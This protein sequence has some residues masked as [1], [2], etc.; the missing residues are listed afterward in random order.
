MHEIGATLTQELPSGLLAGSSI[1]SVECQA[2]IAGR[3]SDPFS[4]TLRQKI[5]IFRAPD[6]W[7]CTR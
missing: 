4:V 5:K 2:S 7:K 3:K 1:L 6:R